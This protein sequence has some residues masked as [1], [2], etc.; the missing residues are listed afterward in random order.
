[1]LLLYRLVGISFFLFLSIV[2]TVTFTVVI[3][4]IFTFTVTVETGQTFLFQQVYRFPWFRVSCFFG[5]IVRF[6]A[7]FVQTD[8]FKCTLSAD[9]YQVSRDT[10]IGRVGYLVA[11]NV[12]LEEVEYTVFGFQFNFF[13][14][15]TFLCLYIAI[16][17]VVEATFQFSTLSC[18][19]LRIERDVLIAC[20]T[21]RYG[22]KGSHPRGTT[23]FTSTRADSTDA[24]SLLS[25]ADLFHFDAHME[26]ICQH[27]YQ[28]AEIYTLIGNVVEDCLVSVS[29]ILY[30]AYFH[31]QIQAEG[32]L[33]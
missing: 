23:Q 19:F 27:F 33:A 15:Q 1:M 24:A 18:Q 14:R 29:L 3:S 17:F 4:T 8:D 32:N 22:H 31:I 16:Y 20:R 30:I 7:T 12:R 6:D 10:L 26:S 21:C 13:G 2:V 9:G 11:Q 25:R 28:L 5:E